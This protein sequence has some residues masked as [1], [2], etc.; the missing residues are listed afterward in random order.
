[1]SL[2]LSIGTANTVRAPATSTLPMLRVIENL[3]GDWRR[4]DDRIDRLSSEIEP[5]RQSATCRTIRQGGL[6]RVDTLSLQLCR[7]KTGTQYKSTQPPFGPC[8]DITSDPNACIG[9]DTMHQ[10]MSKAYFWAND[11]Q[12]YGGDCAA[13]S[14]HFRAR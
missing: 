14:R 3:A 9:D 5:Y 13:L 1:A 6:H 8:T 10:V 4:L 12:V 7:S 2:F 11:P